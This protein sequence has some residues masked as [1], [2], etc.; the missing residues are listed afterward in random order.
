MKLQQQP[1][2]Q[3]QSGY[4]YNPPANPLK[5]QEATPTGYTYSVPPVKLQEPSKQPQLGGYNYPAPANPLKLQQRPLNF[6][7]LV[8]SAASPT[9]V[10]G[11]PPINQFSQ[12]QTS[13]SFPCNKIPWLPMFPNPQ[14]MD[15]LRAKLQAKNPSYL[16]P[17][18][19]G[20]QNIQPIARPQPE[21]FTQQLNAHT[22]LPPR[23]RPLR[24]PS[25][26]QI[27]SINSLNSLPL[28][29]TPQPFKSPPS[30]ISSAYLPSQNVLLPVETT[31]HHLVPIPVPNL[32][33]TPIPPLYDP[34]PFTANDAQGTLYSL[35]ALKFSHKQCGRDF[36]WPEKMA[37][38]FKD[39]I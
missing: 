4:T 1:N 6:N 31:Q 15:M 21:K 16:Y 23:Q 18:L 10:Y 17:Q 13:D 34:K 9:A 32:S 24:Q 20:Y 7:D 25:Q 14:E 29:G 12:A 36:E 39:L 33:I 2:S 8:S 30:T 11:L 3:P 19:N 26:S 27:N 38:N 35:F 5:L 28:Q 37:R 22:Y